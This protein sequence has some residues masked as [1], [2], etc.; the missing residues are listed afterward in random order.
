MRRPDE[1]RPGDAAVTGLAWTTALGDDVEATWQ[2]LLDGHDGFIPVPSSHPVRNPL[3]APACA[4]RANGDDHAARLHHMACDTLTRA[5][6]DAA[7]SPAGLA[8]VAGTSFGARLDP[9]PAPPPDA[10]HWLHAVARGVGVDGP[11]VP[12]SSACSTGSDALAVAAMLL[13]ER[14]DRPVVCGAVDLLTPAKRYGHT[15]LATMSSTR[16]RPFDRTRDGMLLGEGAG[17]VVLESQESARRRGV[18]VHGRLRGAAFSN[19]G[20]GLTSPD[21]SG[22]G[23][24]RTVRDAL[25]LAG[26]QPERIGVV[27]A[28]ATATALNDLT[29]IRALNDVFGPQRRPPVVFALK[30]SVGHTLGATGAL[31]A[32]AVLLALRDRMAPPVAGLRDPD[33]GLRLPTGRGRATPLSSAAP[34]GLSLTLGFGGFNTCLVLEGPQEGSRGAR[35]ARNP[36]VPEQGGAGRA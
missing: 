16:M 28:H 11:V 9:G 22:C 2:T 5:L 8:L 30:S 24:A 29:E 4:D 18:R 17:F 27:G 34:L 36:S 13:A 10:A 19:D 35:T 1:E 15:A 6:K 32:I 21:T 20:A 31:Q 12:V 25:R 3:A 7:L 26:A 14:P 23:V 33:P